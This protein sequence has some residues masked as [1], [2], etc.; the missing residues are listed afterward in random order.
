M[1]LSHYLPQ[2]ILATL[3]IQGVGVLSRG[4]SNRW[5]ITQLDFYKVVLASC[6]LS[7]LEASLA[8]YERG[9]GL[10]ESSERGD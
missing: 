10:C 3:D 8:C 7:D 4:R 9:C 6:M 5:Y 2:Q 1:V